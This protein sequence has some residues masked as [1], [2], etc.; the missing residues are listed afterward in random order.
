MRV[1]GVHEKVFQAYPSFRRGIVIAR[2][3]D[4]HGK[5]EELEK[6]LLEAVKKA[7]ENPVDL[8][9]DPRITCWLAAHQGFS[10]NPNKFP[11][12][13]CSLLKRV[14]KPGSM[15][16]FI[17]K[18]VAIMNLCSITGITPV[19]GDDLD[20][21]GTSLELRYAEG[22]ESFTPLDAPD[23]RENPYPGEI[24]YVV[25]ETGEVMCRR[26]NWRNGYITRITEETK[27][28]VMN[29]DGLGED[30]EANTL[31]IRDRVAELLRNY[32]GAETETSLLSPDNGRYSF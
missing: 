15:I 25:P 13:Q 12:A 30:N 31:L 17:S 29:I 23:T 9:E 27:T 20:S 21:A 11:P 16:P 14:Q 26:W 7:G 6:L 24:I 5:S 28:L 18:I 32:C 19:G 3:L 4:N 2:N 8:K 10:S 22:N 1:T